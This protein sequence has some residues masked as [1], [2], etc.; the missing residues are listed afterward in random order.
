MTDE[1]FTKAVG[2]ELAYVGEV[3]NSILD[4]YINLYGV[5]IYEQGENNEY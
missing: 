3:L 4:Y 5:D 1:E 2:T